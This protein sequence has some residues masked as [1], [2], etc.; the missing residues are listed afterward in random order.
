MTNHM[1]IKTAQTRAAALSEFGYPVAVIAAK[2]TE[3]F[4]GYYCE[5]IN[6]AIPQEQI[7]EVYQSGKLVIVSA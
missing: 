3:L 4:S 5:R 1:S 7:V 2:P 6:S